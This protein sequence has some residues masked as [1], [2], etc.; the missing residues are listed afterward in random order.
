VQNGYVKSSFFPE[1]ESDQIEISVELPEGT[2]YARA[3]EILEQLQIAEKK[4]V[5]EIT[6]KDGDLIE[7]WYTR[8]RDDNI[9]ALV[10]LVPPE[11]RAL[12]AKDTAERLRE[13]IGDI[14]DAKNIQVNYQ[15]TNNG[16]PIQYVLNAKTFEDLNAAADDLMDQL[17]SYEG[18]FN[19]VNDMESASE[20]V[21][22]DLRPGAEA[23]G[24][25]TA[26]VARQLRQGF[27]GEEVQRLPR[28]GED[29]RVFVRY[30]RADRT[31]LDFL[32]YVRRSIMISLIALIRFIPK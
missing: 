28:D 2:P 26:D 27:F 3:L 30:P 15:D 16:P 20:E 13:L 8:S 11:T 1:T 9:L 24:V 7:N 14:P 6:A 5:E 21:Q 25:T 12:S 22:F 29:V 31:S 10:K 19:V 23:L 18:V 4:L 32:E 17:R